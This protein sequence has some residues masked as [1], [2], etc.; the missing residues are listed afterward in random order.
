[1]HTEFITLNS[2]LILN[3]NAIIEKKLKT[4]AEEKLTLFIALIALLAFLTVCVYRTFIDRDY[5]YITQ[6]I[7][8]LVW[9]VP[10]IKRIY[11]LLF[12]KTWNSTIRIDDIQNVTLTRLENGLETQVTLYLKSGRRKFLIFRNAESQ[13]EG[14][15]NSIRPK[16]VL[17]LT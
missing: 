15:I 17:P 8:V 3:N 5:F 6:G 2:R 10:H 11:T 14:F 7:L 1:M 13:A 16:K 12:V 9:L 4:N